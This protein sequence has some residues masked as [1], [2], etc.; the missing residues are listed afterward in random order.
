[1]HSAGFCSGP[2]QDHSGLNSGMAQFHQNNWSPEWQFWQ[3]SLPKM[4]PLD[5]GRNHRGMI[6]TLIGTGKSSPR[7][8]WLA[9]FRIPRALTVKWLLWHYL[10]DW[11]ISIVLSSCAP[12]YWLLSS[13]SSRTPLTDF[14][15]IP[16]MTLT[17]A[18]GRW[19]PGYPTFSMSLMLP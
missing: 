10:I 4:I 14:Q 15:I 1:M 17:S 16:V 7:K 2:F 18:S 3:G 13:S 8:I 9:K 6:K 12:H 19:W 5:S 11:C